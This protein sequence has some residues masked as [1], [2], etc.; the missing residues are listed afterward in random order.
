MLL[1]FTLPSKEVVYKLIGSII[2]KYRKDLKLLEGKALKLLPDY[3][4]YLC[5]INLLFREGNRSIH[6]CCMVLVSSG[7][8][9]SAKLQQIVQGEEKQ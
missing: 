2:H 5:K 1:P 9:I 6:A 7:N 4:I 8:V 3:V